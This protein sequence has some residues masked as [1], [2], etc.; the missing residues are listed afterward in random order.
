MTPLEEMRVSTLDEVVL[1]KARRRD[2]WRTGP[3]D[4]KNSELLE[5]VRDYLNEN[6]SVTLVYGPR[7]GAEVDRVSNRLRTALK[8]MGLEVETSRQE[9]RGK[10][11][12]LVISL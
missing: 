4:D 6:G 11:I 1:L 7:D 5:Q 8:K 12:N 2:N 3:K 10:H 9:I